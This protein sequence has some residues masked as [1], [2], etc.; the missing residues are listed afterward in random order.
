MTAAALATS[1][2]E[3]D[4][5]GSFIAQQLRAGLECSAAGR[6]EEAIAAY[7]RGLA[8]AE[9]ALPAEG[10]VETISELHSRLGN[11]CMLRGDLALAAD[12]YKAAL[13]LAPH[14]TDCWCNLG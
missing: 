1:P 14:R 10:P 9:N 3:T 8:A 7:Q 5:A 2:G 4:I 12:S 6:L 13:R 11:A